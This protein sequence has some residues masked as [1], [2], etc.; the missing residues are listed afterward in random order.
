M[1]SMTGELFPDLPPVAGRTRLGEGAWLLHGF[2]AETGEAL[3]Q[4]IAAVAREAPFRHLLTPGGRRMSVAMTNCGRVGWYSDGKGYRY[5]RHDPASGKRWPPMPAAFRS[6][7]LR[8]AATAGY[9]D[10][11]PDV[12]LVN[13]YQ[14]GARLT[15]HQDKDEGSFEQPIVSLSLGVPARFV[16]GGLE[17]TDRGQRVALGH[18]DVVVWGGP[19]RKVYHGIA[20]LA[21]AQHALTGELRYNVTFRCARRPESDGPM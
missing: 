2:A 4:A 17:R 7:A 1:M 3:L 11:R 8:A 5:V 12:A 19:S 15:L 10:Y 13:R 14:P 6:L 21:R 18:G 9:P 20:P 16:F